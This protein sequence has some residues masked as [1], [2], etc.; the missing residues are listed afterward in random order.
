MGHPDVI[1]QIGKEK[2]QVR[3]KGAQLNI[4]HSVKE[5]KEIKFCGGNGVQ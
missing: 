4:C 5:A 1:T 3:S 2:D